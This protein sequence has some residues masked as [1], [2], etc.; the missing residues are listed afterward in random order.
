MKRQLLSF[1]LITATTL[2]TAMHAQPFQASGITEPICDVMLAPSVPG[3]VGAWK[4][5]EGDF[6][7]EG[8]PIIE[9]DKKLEELETER[10]RLAMENKKSDWEAL[11]TLFAKSSIS[12][13]KEELDKAETD[14]KIAA[15][16]FEMAAE[17]LRKRSITAPCSGFVAEIARDPGES[18]QAYQPVVRVVDTRQCYLVCN[19]E[20]KTTGRLKPGQRVKLEIEATSS[21]LPLQGK[22]TFISPIVDPASGL[23]KIK[24]LFENADAHVRPGVAGKAIFE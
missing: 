9:L 19:I 17:Q 14:Y 15:I 5:K 1:G 11:K 12:V 20:A 23:Q 22:I 6:V 4:L 18:C 2:T 13:K 3:L 8:E 10:R 16:E 7:K 21:P 24:V